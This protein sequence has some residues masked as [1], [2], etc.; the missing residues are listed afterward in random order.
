ME[1]YV[2]F[3]NA[4]ERH[5]DGWAIIGLKVDTDKID[6]INQEVVLVGVDGSFGHFV[7]FSVGDFVTVSDDNPNLGSNPTSIITAIDLKRPSV[8]IQSIKNDLYVLTCDNRQNSI[9]TMDRFDFDKGLTTIRYLDSFYRQSPYA[10]IILEHAAAI[11]TVER[12][13]RG[14]GEEPSLPQQHVSEEDNEE[15]DM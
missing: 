6:P 13:I 7:D 3:R 2:C 8:K 11:T 12:R 5:E 1:D 15:N 9:L 14:K 10:D 4:K